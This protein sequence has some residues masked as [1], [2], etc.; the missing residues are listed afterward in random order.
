MAP[1]NIQL[2]PHSELEMTVTAPICGDCSPSGRF[3]PTNRSQCADDF[4]HALP[5]TQ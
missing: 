5:L 3:K 1:A 4:G 2:A